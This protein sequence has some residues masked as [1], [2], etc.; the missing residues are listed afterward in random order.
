MVELN[1]CREVKVNAPIDKYARIEIDGVLSL[2]FDEAEFT[3]LRDACDSAI[4]LIEASTRPVEAPI[5][6]QPDESGTTL[7]VVSESIYS[8][9]PETDDDDI[10]F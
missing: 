4:K 6:Q 8:P 5:Y 1:H 3:R 9:P 2:F 10:P 7:A